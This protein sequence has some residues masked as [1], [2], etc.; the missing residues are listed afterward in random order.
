MAWVERHQA[1]PNQ[2]VRGIMLA[3]EISDDLKL[4]CS[5]IPNVELYEYELSMQLRQIAL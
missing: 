1:E 3:R 5:G 2:D 4:A